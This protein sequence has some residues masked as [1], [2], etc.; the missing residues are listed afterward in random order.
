MRGAFLPQKSDLDP[1][2]QPKIAQRGGYGLKTL[3]I[4]IYE[5][6]PLI[7]NI[8]APFG[9]TSAS[10]LMKCHQQWGYGGCFWVKT[11]I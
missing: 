1:L 3:P 2:G 7:L 9:A 5:W 10:K 8:L 6:A 4:T 11:P